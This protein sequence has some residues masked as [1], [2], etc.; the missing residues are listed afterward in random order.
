MRTS[1]LS[2]WQRPRLRGIGLL[3]VQDD[4]GG[5]SELRGWKPRSFFICFFI[6]CPLNQVEYLAFASFIYASVEDFGE[7]VFRVGVDDDWGFRDLDLVRE[8]VQSGGF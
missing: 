3:K 1:R 7:F 4:F 2:K 8:L 6:A 5:M